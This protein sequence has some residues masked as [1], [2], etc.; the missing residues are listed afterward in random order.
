[1]WDRNSM[2]Q[3]PKHKQTAYRLVLLPVLSRSYTE[4]GWLGRGVAY[5]VSIASFGE[6]CNSY[7]C[8]NYNYFSHDSGDRS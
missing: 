5:L 7:C 4:C 1:M 2:S 3:F 6:H 8:H